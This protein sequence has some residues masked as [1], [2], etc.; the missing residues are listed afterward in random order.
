MQ[1]SVQH[2]HLSVT[3]KIILAKLNKKNNIWK[4]EL[5]VMVIFLWTI[6]F[7]CS[8]LLFHYI[9]TKERHTRYRIQ[10]E[11]VFKRS[12]WKITYIN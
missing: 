4:N 12:T 3:V 10:R 8:S 7:N 9:A 5:N 2:T 1:L 6:P 11:A